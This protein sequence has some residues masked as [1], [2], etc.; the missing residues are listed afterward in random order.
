MTLSDAFDLWVLILWCVG[1]CNML[2]VDFC[3]ADGTWQTSSASDPSP[4]L[5]STYKCQTLRSL[6]IFHTVIN[7]CR[8]TVV[9]LIAYRGNK[10]LIIKCNTKLVILDKFFIQFTC[11]YYYQE[12]PI[13]LSLILGVSL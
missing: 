7:Y 11:A 9:G 3:L 6:L 13:Y 2:I 4:C 12:D 1:T 8:G 5:L 10:F